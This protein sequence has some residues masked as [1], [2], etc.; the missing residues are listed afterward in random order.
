MITTLGSG[1]TTAGEV[2][3]CSVRAYDGISY[4]GYDSNFTNITGG[5]SVLSPANAFVVDRDSY[6]PIDPD[7]TTMAVLS[8]LTSL[9]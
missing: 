9:G 4:S 5:I 6:T 1:N 8:I 2:W 3:N 7:S